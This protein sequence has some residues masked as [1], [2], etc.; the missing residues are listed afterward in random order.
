MQKFHFSLLLSFLIGFFS[1]SQEIL[2]VRIVSYKLKGLPQ[3]FSLTLAIFLIGISLGAHIGQRVCKQKEFRI[4]ILLTT[5]VYISGLFDLFLPDLIEFSNSKFSDNDNL[6]IIFGL[7]STI[8][9]LIFILL[10]S[11]LKGIIFPIAH[12]LGTKIKTKKIGISI[13]F[14]YF[15]NILGSVTG[16]I[17]TGYYFFNIFSMN[18]IFLIIGY[19]QL[20]LATFI[21][22]KYLNFKFIL[23][24]PILVLFI[25]N[26][27]INK[28]GIIESLSAYPTNH[29]LISIIENRHGILTTSKS[30][31][32]TESSLITY[33]GNIFDGSNNTDLL[34]NDNGID[35][36][37][38]ASI[39]VDDPKKILFIGIGSGSWIKVISELTDAE[40]IDVVELNSGYL[41][42]LN[43]DIKMIPILNDKRINIYIDDGRRWIKKNKNNKYDLIVSNTTYHWRS[44]ATNLLSNEFMLLIKKI[45]NSNGVYLFNATRSID[46]FYTASKNFNYSYRYN[47]FV[48]NSDTNLYKKNKEI[49]KDLKKLTE[50]KSSNKINSQN[51]NNLDIKF[52]TLEEDLLNFSRKPEVISDK[53]M[54]S[55]YKYGKLKTLFKELLSNF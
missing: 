14:I 36:A 16:P 26:N 3:S 20:F 54:I 18:E 51:F 17:I 44:N 12:H 42:L 21:A 5:I 40:S 29:K 49:I 37:F 4:W 13:S 55:E 39:L 47:S 15:M 38:L 45:L 10:S 9:L 50:N 48:Y 19:G 31:Y 23:T 33:G 43:Q 52:A 32:D 28:H 24:L 8:S 11:F 53:N 22:L 7:L 25:F 27:K 41:E 1:L 46:S 2:W 35:R 30:A 6:K 34:K